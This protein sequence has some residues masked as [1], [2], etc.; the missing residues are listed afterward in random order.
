MII[1]KEFIWRK[2]HFVCHLT[3][4]T[5]MSSI[6]NQGLLPSNGKRCQ[7]VN[8]ERVGLFFFDG[9]YNLQNW[10]EVLY[11]NNELEALKILRFNIKNR[12]WYIDNSNERA[13]GFYLTNKVLPESISYLNITDKE[14]I[15]KPITKLFDLDF[16]HKIDYSFYNIDNGKQIIIDDFNLD[17]QPIKE[18]KVKQLKK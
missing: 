4:E 3:E 18:Y 14:G 6:I 8:D 1:S 16:L 12:K 9:L 7:S 17:W 11:K 5:N 13:L 15:E 10:A 2:D